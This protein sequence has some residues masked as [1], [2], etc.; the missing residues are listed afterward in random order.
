MMDTNSTVV[1]RRSPHGREPAANQDLDADASAAESLWDVHTLLKHVVASLTQEV[2]RR[3]AGENLTLAKAMPLLLML[4]SPC[5]TVTSIARCGRSNVGAMTRT[6]FELEERGMISRTRSIDDRR[7]V[8]LKLTKRGRR[9]ATTLPALVKAAADLH[10]AGFSSHDRQALMSY[11]QRL[12][13]DDVRVF[14]SRQ[15]SRDARR[16]TTQMEAPPLTSSEAPL[17]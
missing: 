4:E 9:V 13:L 8:H 7:V 6:V 11:L 5:T 3:L 1:T 2:D 14:T 15:E 12:T 17:T 10:F 16:A